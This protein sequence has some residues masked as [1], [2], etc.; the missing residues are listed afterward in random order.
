[1]RA[2]LSISLSYAI[3]FDYY[4]ADEVLAVG[5]SKFST[6][7]LEHL[8][9]IANETGLIFVS[10]NEAQVKDFCDRCILLSNGQKIYDGDVDEG[11]KIYNQLPA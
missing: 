10:H 2:K 6:K 8:K 5:D 7:C 11:F 1:M 4:L 3:K 9:S